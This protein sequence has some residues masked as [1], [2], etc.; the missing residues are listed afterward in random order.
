MN[1]SLQ[2]KTKKDTNKMTEAQPSQ[3]GETNEHE[4]SAEEIAEARHHLG[5]EAAEQTVQLDTNEASG[6]A[7]HTSAETTSMI[8]DYKAEHGSVRRL[9]MKDSVEHG[10]DPDTILLRIGAE[11][12][13]EKLEI[14]KINYGAEPNTE[15]WRNM[16][17]IEARYV[18]M[19]DAEID[20]LLA[21]GANP[22]HI[23]DALQ[24]TQPEDGIDNPSSARIAARIDKLVEAGLPPS[25]LAA[26]L[27]PSWRE[28]TKDKLAASEEKWR[29]DNR[30]KAV[31]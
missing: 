12:L 29:E 7:E 30:L 9:S 6:E 5:A 17:E 1:K 20:A 15:K 26:R 21:A 22:Q 14:V 18:P 10:F 13:D 23:V 24:R 28:A 4:F 8:D 31:A 16:E 11:R 3:Q 2:V 19:S 27:N 25:V